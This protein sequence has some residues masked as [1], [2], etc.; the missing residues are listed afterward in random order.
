MPK[1]LNASLAF[2]NFP[3]DNPPETRKFLQDLFGIDLVPSLS[4]Q[5]SYHAPISDDGIDVNVGERHTPQESA[6]AFISVDDLNTA[7][8]LAKNSG[9]NV[10]WGPDDVRIPD[11]DLDEYKRA[12]KEVDKVDVKSNSLGRAAIVVDAGGS[13]IGLV[14]LAD[15]SEKHFNAG[16]YRQPLS[17][18]RVTAHQRTQQAA[19]DRGR[20]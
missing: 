2:I 1:K 13:Q 8:D 20:V 15:H 6:T 11:A 10:V 12:V 16:K 3:S 19:H 5:T 14:Q 4:D 7:I 18:Y 9:G 17:D